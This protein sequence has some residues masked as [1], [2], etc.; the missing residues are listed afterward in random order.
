MWKQVEKMFSS[1][2]DSRLN[3]L[4]ETYTSFCRS[5]L[6]I[7]V[8]SG[9]IN[10]A[11]KI[12][13]KEPHLAL[14]QDSNGFTPL[15]LASVRKSLRMVRLLL[16]AEPGACIVQDEDGRTPLHLA[17]MK[18]RVE[19]MK[20][21]IKE[22]LPEAIHVKN[23][24]NGE[25]I[26]H[27]CVKSNTNLETLELLTDYLVGAQPPYPDSVSI[28]SKDNDG[29]TILHLAVEMGNMR[30]VDYLLHNRDVRIDINITN[31]KG[32]KALNMLSQAKKNDL[33]FG[34]YD[35]HAR[36]HTSKTL[37]KN[38]DEHEVLK[39]RVN[40]L[41][42][43][44]TLIAGIAFQA[45]MNPPGGVWQDD[46]RVNSNTDPVT[47]AYYLGSMYSS[48][49]SGGLEEYMEI[50]VPD[51]LISDNR[52]GYFNI[53]EFVND[54]INISSGSYAGMMNKG[55]IL[56]DF[57]FTDAI[58]NYN[59][60]TDGF[61][62]YLIRYA[63]YPILAYTFPNNYVIY[64]VNNGVALLASLTIIALVAC[65]FMIETTINQVR[66]LVVLMCISIA[67][68]AFSYMSILDAMLPFYYVEQPRA[69]VTLQIFFGVG[70]ILGAG[71]FTWTLTR[72]IIKLRKRMWYQHIE[73][74][75]YLNYLEAF[76]FGMD[77]K[78]AAKVILF[79]VSY[80]AFR[81][82]GYI[83]YGTWSKVSLF[84]C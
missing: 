54:L 1:G 15:H 43:V 35:Y 14:K 39:K 81:L 16:K 26:L 10:F 40:A 24:Q 9:D 68:V 31:K 44:A 64:M 76:F 72:E 53:K 74:I 80:F 37:S 67:C 62:P 77:A 20:A 42:L 56:E 79:T 61:F 11:T 29:N 7:A 2:K 4:D 12:L 6:H 47:F 32:L 63:G 75:S 82:N 36:Q 18:N 5:P 58:L 52:G 8:M 69:F 51:D 3:N 41:M 49:V 13:S 30:I 23:D 55:L 48:Y 45:A 19:I 22:G 57:R 84:L 65:G 66:F 50:H 71:L 38:G 28:N 78:A 59:T 17:A 33:K 25:T 73:F 34:F 46:S 70:I 83:Y 60:S 21:L 27:G